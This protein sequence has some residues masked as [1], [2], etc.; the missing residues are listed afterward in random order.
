MLY[1]HL[2]H[3]LF[4]SNHPHTLTS[5]P[6]LTFSTLLSSQFFSSR[7]IFFWLSLSSCLSHAYSPL[8]LSLHPPL[9]TAT[10]H[11]LFPFLSPS[12]LS[13]TSHFILIVQSLHHSH[14]LAPRSNLTSTQWR[15]HG[16]GGG[17][18]GGCVCMEMWWKMRHA[19]IVCP[20]TCPS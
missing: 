11:I 1:H 16:G 15:R 5:S 6:A 13:G 18:R 10:T 3:W 2:S 8:L 19:K 9:T 14:S 12:T 7:P 4:R 20:T 17:A